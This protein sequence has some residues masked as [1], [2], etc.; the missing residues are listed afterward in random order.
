MGTEAASLSRIQLNLLELCDVDLP[1]NWHERDGPGP[2]LPSFEKLL[3]L[4]FLSGSYTQIDQ[5]A[6]LRLV[7]QPAMAGAESLDE[8]GTRRRFVHGAHVLARDRLQ[9]L[10]VALPTLTPP[11]HVGP[12]NVLG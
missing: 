1:H 7:R 8:M 10:L 5:A 4:L 9:V 12:Q 6:Q 2:C 3:R 11:D